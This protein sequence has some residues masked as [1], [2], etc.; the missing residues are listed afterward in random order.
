[1]K[2]S[3]IVIYTDGG[4]RGNPGPA[5]CAFVININ[6]KEVFKQSKYLG[7]QT[8]NF[9]EY[10]GVILA[11]K[12]LLDKKPDNKLGNDAIFYLDS[13]LI[14]MQ[15]TG[16]YKVKS[17]SLRSLYLETVD[18]IS[19]TKQKIYF[20]NVPRERNKEADLLVNKELDNSL[21]K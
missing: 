17:E 8:N 4:S 18:L 6:G 1:M 19:K 15:L 7:R 14:A 3:Q 10:Q 11:L 20:R 16:R 21:K 12:Y 2:D 9:A 5:A 13:E